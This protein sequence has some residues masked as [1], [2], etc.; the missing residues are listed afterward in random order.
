[1]KYPNKLM[2]LKNAPTRGN[3]KLTQRKT[4]REKKKKNVEKNEVTTTG[5]P[6]LN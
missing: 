1:M 5:N 2:E 6:S 4:K 3:S